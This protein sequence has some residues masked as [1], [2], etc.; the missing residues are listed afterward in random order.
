M[1]SYSASA[2]KKAFGIDGGGEPL[3]FFYDCEATGLHVGKDNIIEVAAVVYTKRLRNRIHP[4]DQEFTSLC[5]CA[6]ELSPEAQRLTGLTQRDLRREPKL[7]EVLNR[8][9]D[10]VHE[11][12]ERVGEREQKCYVPVLAAHSGS[13]LDFPMLFHAVKMIGSQPRNRSLKT[14][15]EELDLHY[16]DTFS[17]FKELSGTGDYP[18][19]EKLGV[20][21]IY[22]TYFG[23][24]GDGH[25]ALEDAKALCKV[26]SE[27][28][29]ESEFMATLRKYVKSK[30][31]EEFTKEQIR[32][33][34]KVDVKVPKV[35]ELLQKEIDYEDFVK[36]IRKSEKNFS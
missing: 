2:K 5:Y 6:R 30:E 21:D 27:A 31:G 35:I 32:K 28:P 17:V 14:K 15:F 29:K 19:L 26:F 10:W 33:F 11:I 7:G 9:F 16:V 34:Y 22:K 1:A 12:V 18:E 20:H 23:D 4:Q 24:S 36:Q 13:K 8:F 3:Y 25:R